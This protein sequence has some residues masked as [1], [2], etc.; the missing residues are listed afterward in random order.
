MPTHTSAPLQQPSLFCS[1]RVR[2]H[3]MDR[4]A[5]LSYILRP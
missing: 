5:A 2:V 4:V 3:D 1:H